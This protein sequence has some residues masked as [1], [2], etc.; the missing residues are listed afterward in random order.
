METVTQATATTV[1]AAFFE[2]LR[3]DGPHPDQAAAPDL[4]GWL[5][6][7][8]DA[9]VVDH[10]ADGGERRQSA[11]MH[12]AWVLE[13]RAIQDL[14]IVPAR[15]D[16]RGAPGPGNRYGTT[17]RIWDA[18]LG[19]WRIRWINPVNGSESTLVARR[20]GAD[21]VQTG[22][23]ASGRLLRWIFE[24][25]QPSSF[26]WRG[27]ISEDGGRTWTCQVEF[28]ARRRVQL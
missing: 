21:I 18:A 27:D 19:A 6:G 10:L 15:R 16:R 2:T 20:V 5:V 17:F 3:A 28:F 26:H 14:W 23:D 9:E 11:E 13:G 24:A 1:P 12:F 25:I 8:W 7:S 4:Y 22:A